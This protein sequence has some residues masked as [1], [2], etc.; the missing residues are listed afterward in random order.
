MHTHAAAATHTRTTVRDVVVAFVVVVT[1]FP[2]N[3]ISILSASLRRG[4]DDA[5]TGDRGACLC[6]FKYASS[7]SAVRDERGEFRFKRLAA[8]WSCARS[9]ESQYADA[10]LVC[11]CVVVSIYECGVKLNR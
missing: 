2:L 4:R 9:S 11:E 3:P 5:A 1:Q 6:T 10:P 8:R 7:S